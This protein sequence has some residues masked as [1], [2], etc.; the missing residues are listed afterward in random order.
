MAL[1]AISQQPLRKYGDELLLMYPKPRKYQRRVKVWVPDEVVKKQEV[2]PVLDAYA[3]AIN[4]PEWVGKD[5][6]WYKQEQ[7]LMLG[8]HLIAW[9]N[10][11]GES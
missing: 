10:G 4:K 11:E 5:H 6:E 1:L 3:L 8:F 7:H 9:D 2:Q